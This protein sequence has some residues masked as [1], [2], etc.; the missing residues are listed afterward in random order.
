MVSLQTHQPWP[1]GGA[2]PRLSW[3]R[4]QGGVSCGAAPVTD[5]TAQGWGPPQLCLAVHTGPYLIP[6]ASSRLV[7]PVQLICRCCRGRRGQ[8]GWKEPG[9][10]AEHPHAPPPWGIQPVGVG[11]P[12]AGCWVGEARPVLLRTRAVRWPAS[13]RDH[14]SSPSARPGQ[15]CTREPPLHP[16]QLCDLGWPLLI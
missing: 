13:C 3:C 9:A 10:Q 2:V 4:E 14:R 16:R 1:S 6:G 11:V 8:L 7:R 15:P 5:H 12:S